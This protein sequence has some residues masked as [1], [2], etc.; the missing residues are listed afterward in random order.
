MI[1]AI[2]VLEGIALVGNPSFAI[3]D[4]AYPY[5]ARRL[6]TDRS[7]R[8]RA[9]LR[10]MVYGR[11]GVFDAENAIDLL[12]ALEKFSAVRDDGDG[13]A[14]K[15]NGVRGNKVV[16]AAGDFVGSQEVD[17]SE[18]D[19]DSRFRVSSE[20]DTMTVAQQTQSDERTVRE[21]LKFFFSPEGDV[22]R[23]F[24]L[25][26]IV[27]VVDASGRGAIQSFQK[28]TGLANFPMPGLLKA[29]NPDITEEDREMTAQIQKLVQFL[30]GDY[31]G[32]ASTARL[33]KL[34]PL[35]REYAPQLREFGLLL[36]ARLTEKNLSRGM[37]WA[38]ER[39]AAGRPRTFVRT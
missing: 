26:E 34:L 19:Q 8:L 31:E 39:L 21:A 27:T 2:S 32:A 25:E 33:R 23:D 6:M 35:A 1:R 7:P 14:F 17:T 18:R 20:T 38:S 16:G 11:D 36:A 5:I 30:L 22:L 9:A 28:R 24:L 10:Y 13:S 29:M 37:N 3:I 12:Q 15:V 4:E